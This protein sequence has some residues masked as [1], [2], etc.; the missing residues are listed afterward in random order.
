MKR[1]EMLKECACLKDQIEDMY[2]NQLLS[3]EKIAAKLNMSVKRIP[4]LIDHFHLTRDASLVQSK[5]L[6]DSEEKQRNYNDVKSRVTKDAII[7]WYMEEDHDYN[8]AADHFD[9]C[10][11]SCARTTASGKTNRSRDTRAWRPARR[12]MVKTTSS[13]SA[14][15]EK[16]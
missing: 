11:T 10:S 7:K 16:R 12:N 15:A 13:T 1:E 6:R 3:Q 2:C 8:D 14:N 4:I 9:P 5:A